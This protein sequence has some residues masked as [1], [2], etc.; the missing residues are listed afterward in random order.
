M[1]DASGVCKHRAFAE[2]RANFFGYPKLP[3]RD[4]SFVDVHSPNTRAGVPKGWA[5]QMFS[6]TEIMIRDD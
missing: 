1:F 5:K 3:E 6:A 2:C 4:G